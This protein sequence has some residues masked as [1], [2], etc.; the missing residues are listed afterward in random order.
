MA[1]QLL[2]LSNSANWELLYDYSASAGYLPG[3]TSN[4]LPIPSVTIPYLF[5]SHV[6]AVYADS[7]TAKDWWITAGWAS[8]RIQTGIII[9]GTPDVRAT[10]TQRLIFREINLIIYPDITATYSM[11]ID[12]PYWFDQWECQVWQYTGPIGDINAQL[13]SNIQTQLER[14]ETKLNTL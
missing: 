13:I 3:S 12:I 11:V 14:M 9:G 4:H 6:L 5:D 10:E 1:T 7:S 8:R 2:E